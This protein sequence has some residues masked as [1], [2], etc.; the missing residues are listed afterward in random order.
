MRDRIEELKSEQVWDVCVSKTRRSE[1]REW[2]A[3][4][5]IYLVAVFS[6]RPVITLTKSV[7]HQVS[8]HICVYLHK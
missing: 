8:M 1:E 7:I 5:H 2:S 4:V 3:T 6:K